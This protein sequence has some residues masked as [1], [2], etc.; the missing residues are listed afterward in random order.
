MILNSAA[1]TRDIP[2]H[3][4]TFRDITG[5]LIKKKRAQKIKSGKKTKDHSNIFSAA[6]KE[7]G[8]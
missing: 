5:H 8:S 7:K 2:G 3:S 4:E 1:E 6:Q